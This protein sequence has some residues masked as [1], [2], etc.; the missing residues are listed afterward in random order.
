MRH[1]SHQHGSLNLA[2]RRKGLAQSKFVRMVLNKG[3]ALASLDH[4]ANRQFLAS[5]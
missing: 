2:N 1:T 4:D 5:A 3:E